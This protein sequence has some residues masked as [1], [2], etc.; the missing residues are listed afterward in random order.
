MD[1]IDTTNVY[2]SALRLPSLMAINGFDI[3]ELKFACATIPLQIEVS[4][5]EFLV[6]DEADPTVLSLMGL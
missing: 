6:L 5:P 1:Y 4:M 2:R 3:C